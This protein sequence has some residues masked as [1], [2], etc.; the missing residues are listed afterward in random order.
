V[1]AAHVVAHVLGNGRLS[2]LD[3]DLEQF[4]MD[5]WRAPQR[6]LATDPS[7]ETSDIGRQGR[8]TDPLPRLPTP[9]QAKATAMPAEQGLWLEDDRCVDQG[10]EQTVEAD[11]DQTI[12]SLQ[13]GSGRRQSLQDN[14]LLPQ[15]EDLSFASGLRATQPRQQR[16][17][18]S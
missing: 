14:E 16:R 17:K 12:Y 3:A 8:A 6:V 10:R 1:T 9:E 15:I 5:T 7:N 2:D 13:P 11:E 4:T 18:K